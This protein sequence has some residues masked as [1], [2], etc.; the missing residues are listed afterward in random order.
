[1]TTSLTTEDSLT[2]AVLFCTVPTLATGARRV[3][4]VNGMQW[5]SSKGSFIREEETQLCKGPGGMAS[6]LRVS[7]RAFRPLTNVS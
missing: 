7:N 5:H 3:A 6:T 4:W 2:L 1:M